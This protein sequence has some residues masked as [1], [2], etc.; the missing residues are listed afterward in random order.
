MEDKEGRREA[1]GDRGKEERKLG[2]GKPRGGDAERERE[3][4][5]GRNAKTWLQEKG[6]PKEIPLE[7]QRGN[8]EGEE[9]NGEAVRQTRRQQR[10]GAYS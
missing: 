1:E 10:G 2:K 8:S 3:R 7:T 5:M 4:A 6:K 9:G